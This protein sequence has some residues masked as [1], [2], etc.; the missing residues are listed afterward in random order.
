MG[1]VFTTIPKLSN[2]PQANFSQTDLKA[3]LA[4]CKEVEG[5]IL[6]RQGT[7]VHEAEFE[8]YLDDWKYLHDQNGE[9]RIATVAYYFSEDPKKAKNWVW[10]C[11]KNRAK[12]YYKCKYAKNNTASELFIEDKTEDTRSKFHHTFIDQ[13]ELTNFIHKLFNEFFLNNPKFTEIE[14]KLLYLKLSCES[15]NH[16][17]S[18]E[19][20]KYSQLDKLS[21]ANLNSKATRI[22]QKF[23]KFVR[24]K[25]PDIKETLS[26]CDFEKE[27]PD[28]LNDSVAVPK[29][30]LQKNI[31]VSYSNSI[32]EK[33]YV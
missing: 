25:H 7:S 27:L 8:D 9:L 13:I 20:R 16:R 18:K 24:A 1:K 14:K 26:S 23:Q 22:F 15:S 28:L 6:K 10:K 33:Q 19:A 29:K 3:S 30:N 31:L 17:F 21:D 32:K 12:D 11:L 2:A 5:D 4:L